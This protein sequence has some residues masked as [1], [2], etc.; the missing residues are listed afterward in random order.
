MKTLDRYI[1]RQF[2]LNFAILCFVLMALFVLVDLIIQLDQFLA[3]GQALKGRFGGAVPAT[4]WVMWDYYGPMV[5]LIYCYCSGLI[6]MGAMGFT[7]AGL[8]RTRELVAMLTSGISMYRVAAPIVVVGAGLSALA[9]P[10]QEL[11]IPR[12]AGKLT[13]GHSELGRATIQKFPIRFSRDTQGRLLSAAEFLPER[14]ELVDLT[15][16]VR[17][18]H[19]EAPMRIAA[20]SATWDEKRGGWVLQEG[21]AIQRRADLTPAGSGATTPK[22]PCPF[23]KTDLTPKVLLARRASIYPRLMALSE[24]Q[25]MLGNPAVDRKALHQVI[26]SRF[27]TLAVNVLILVMV[28]PFFLLREPANLLAQ[29]IKAVALGI[30]AWVTALVMLQTST[31]ALNPVTSAWLPV[32]IFLPLSALLLT[33]VRT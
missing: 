19:G 16:L 1:L 17:D 21:V 10:L 20:K 25:Q 12:L 5:L 14:E 22:A 29:G 9:L 6:V 24:L 13:R 28:L 18:Q 30:G 7:L 4:L 8:T 31:E 33:R 23:F 32:V 11:A 15:I 2:L 27:S 26:H 3:A